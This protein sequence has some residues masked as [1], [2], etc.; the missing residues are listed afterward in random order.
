[1]LET[2]VWKNKTWQLAKTMNTQ[3]KTDAP[4]LISKE[5]LKQARKN[6]KTLQIDKNVT[7]I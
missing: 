7:Q 4:P 2:I 3:R 6:S 1:M 5:G